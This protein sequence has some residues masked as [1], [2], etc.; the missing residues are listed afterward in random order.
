MKN[1]PSCGVSVS[2]NN[3]NHVM[4]FT[5]RNITYSTETNISEWKIIAFQ[6]SAHTQAYEA[7]LTWPTALLY[8]STYSPWPAIAAK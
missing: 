4:I 1:R 6:F 8:T 5:Y 2:V 7:G 3:S